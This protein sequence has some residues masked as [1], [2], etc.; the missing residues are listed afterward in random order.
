MGLPAP[1]CLAK[2]RVVIKRAK[3]INS[4]LQGTMGLEGQGLD[5]LSLRA[6]KRQTVL[7]LLEKIYGPRSV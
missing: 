3:L 7:D 1:H 2:L 5:V 6:F 4:M